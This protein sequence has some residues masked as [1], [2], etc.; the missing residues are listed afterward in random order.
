MY[1]LRLCPFFDR[2][3]FGFGFGTLIAGF[4]GSFFG[5]ALKQIRSKFAATVY[6]STGSNH[7]LFFKRRL[8]RS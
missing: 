5:T 6:A 1:D 4:D 7:P 3:S 8:S 2:F